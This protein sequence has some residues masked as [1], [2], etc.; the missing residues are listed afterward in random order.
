MPL[1]DVPSEVQQ[2]ERGREGKVGSD[3]F[4]ERLSE[5]IRWVHLT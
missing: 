1:Q 5:Q 2:R 3:E 4:D